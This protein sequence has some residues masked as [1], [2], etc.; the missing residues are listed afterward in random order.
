MYNRLVW[1][2]WTCYRA[3]FLH[4]YLSHSFIQKCV[5]DVLIIARAAEAKNVTTSA[6]CRDKLSYAGVLTVIN[7]SNCTYLTIKRSIIIDPKSVLFII[8]GK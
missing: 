1:G 8:S 7:T 6:G 5:S 4:V 3:S 2:E